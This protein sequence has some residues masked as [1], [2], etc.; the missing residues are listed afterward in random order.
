MKVILILILIAIW[1]PQNVLARSSEDKRRI[2]EGRRK[3]LRSSE[4]Y[5]STR[6]EVAT[7]SIDSTKNAYFS[8]LLSKDV[9]MRSDAYKILAILM[10]VENR[11][12][13]RD[14]QFNFLKEEGIIPK[15]L[16][17]GPGY[18]KP[19]SKGV[20]AYMF[21]KVLDIK[22]GIT[23]RIFGINQRYAFKELVHEEI[24]FPGNT[25]DIVSG[26]EL[27]L[28]LTQAADYMAD[29]QSERQGEGRP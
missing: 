17:E 20:A 4:S 7:S 26:Q 29:R 14:S 24:M 21:V 18:D 19:L 16:I 9:A 15:S 1:V 2:E 5:L 10:G 28:L 6:D 23:L 22:G 12:K 11:F 25:Y 13:G 8:E 27:I 3:N